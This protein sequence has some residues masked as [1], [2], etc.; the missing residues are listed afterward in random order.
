LLITHLFPF[1]VHVL[2]LPLN[3]LSCSPADAQAVQGPARQVCGYGGGLGPADRSAMNFSRQSSW[4]SLNN[5]WVAY[6]RKQD[7]CDI[8]SSW[9]PVKV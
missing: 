7:L 2:L 8:S 5:K 6:Q 9:C 4:S 1:A 3:L